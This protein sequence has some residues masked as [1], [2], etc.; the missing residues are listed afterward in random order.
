MNSRSYISRQNTPVIPLPNPG[1]GGPVVTPDD[2]ITTPNIPPESDNYPVIPLPNPGEGGPVVT[3][4]DEVNGG[5][6]SG[7]VTVPGILGT[8]ITV[9]P[10]PINPCFFCSTPQYGT[11]RFLNASAGYNPFLIYINN[12]LVV[13]SLDND[14]IS[15][16][17]RVSSG[18]QTITVSGQN[19]YVY[20]QKQVSVK[21]GA[22]LTVA[23]INRPGG[24]LDLMTITDSSCQSGFGTGCFRVANLSATNQSLNV[25]LNN[26]INFRNVNYQDVTGF[27]YITVGNYTVRVFNNPSVTGTALV[28]S[29]FSLR[30]NTAYTLY[31]FNW[32]PSKDAI[33]TL[34]VEDKS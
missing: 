5:G 8:I 18:S 34:I 27:S 2:E 11:I 31:I 9:F 10:K 25:S 20:I 23:I 21:A 28:T 15:E 26:F 13:D 24:G 7:S 3:P 1:E 17:G 22:A 19:G 4:D 14:E 6:T 32:N 30:S 12:Q 16:Y 29:T 33:R